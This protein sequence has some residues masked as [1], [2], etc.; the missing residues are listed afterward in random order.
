MIQF[1]TK[2]TEWNDMPKQLKQYKTRYVYNALYNDDRRSR[3]ETYPIETSSIHLIMEQLKQLIEAKDL[4]ALKNMLNADFIHPEVVEFKTETSQHNE[5]WEYTDVSLPLSTLYPFGMGLSDM[6]FAVKMQNEHT[7][8]PKKLISYQSDSYEYEMHDVQPVL[9]VLVSLEHFKT[10]Y[11]LAREDNDV[12]NVIL[13]SLSNKDFSGSNLSEFDLSN[14]DFSSSDLSRAALGL[15]NG[16]DFT[17]ANLMD[18]VVS[19]EALSTA[20]TYVGAKLPA[21]YGRFW[22]EETKESV[23]E[24]IQELRLAAAKYK[25]MDP[26]ASEKAIELADILREMIQKPDVKY[27][28]QFQRNFLKTL[29]SYDVHFQHAPLIQAIIGS[30]ALFLLSAGIGYAIAWGVRAYATE[31]KD[32]LFFNQTSI[33]TKIRDAEK[34]M[35]HYSP[36]LSMA[37]TP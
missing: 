25:K 33:E 37:T 36:C 13:S 14:A 23:L 17:Q 5:V 35:T 22:T 16:A 24:K 27:H 12:L 30:L 32:L 7:Y 31:N 10:I 28:E 6:S 3:V 29:R 34:I 2:Y 8:A 15:I 19:K 26:T 18:A 9:E 11:E 1:R 21:G 4:I 20:K